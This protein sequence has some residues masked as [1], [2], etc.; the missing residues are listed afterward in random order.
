M[1]TQNLFTEKHRRVLTIIGL[2]CISLTFQHCEM[3]D[4]F[5]DLQ[6]RQLVLTEDVISK[7]VKFAESLNESSNRTFDKSSKDKV[8]LIGYKTIYF[9]K[10]E[11]SKFLEIYYNNQNKLDSIKN[12]YFNLENYSIWIYFPVNSAII[13]SSNRLIEASEFGDIFLDKDTNIGNI[14]IIGRRKTDKVTGVKSNIIKNDTIY[15]AKK[16]KA[17]HVNNE[18]IYVFDFGEKVMM[19]HQSHN[20]MASHSNFNGSANFKIEDEGGVSC[21]SNHGGPNCSNAFGIN[22]GRCAPT[23]THCMDYN[24]WFTN[25]QNGST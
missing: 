25:C 5:E 20:S 15:L 10:E 23:T 6:Q 4:S 3:N 8:K 22:Q 24:G 11:A 18:N 21:M 13:E 12:Y 9:G 7:E 16:I 1:T 17:S 2:L 14:K 19:N